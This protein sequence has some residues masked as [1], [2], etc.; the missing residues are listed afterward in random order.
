M[1]ED[2]GIR[3]IS[4]KG[5]SG[6]TEKKKWQ[7]LDGTSLK[8]IAMI[9]MVFDHVGD[10]FFPEQLWMRVIG[11]IALPI[12]AFFVAE[13]FCHTRDRKKYLLRMGVFACLS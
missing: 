13:C 2:A 3:G 9:S 8:L 12:F 1:V 10:N 6:V 11:R 4:E 7:V 5:G